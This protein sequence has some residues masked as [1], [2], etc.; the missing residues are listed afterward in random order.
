MASDEKLNTLAKLTKLSGISNGTLDRTR[1]GESA[2]RVDELEGLAKALGV[3]PW[4]L[5]VPP[6]DRPAISAL[7]VALKAATHVEPARPKQQ[8]SAA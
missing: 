6:A 4:E 8:R 1:R 5:L 3:E 7:R 2:M